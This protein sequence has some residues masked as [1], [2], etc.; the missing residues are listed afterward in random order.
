MSEIK[1]PRRTSDEIREDLRNIVNEAF[2][3]KNAPDMTTK[4]SISRFVSGLLSESKN[5]KLTSFLLRV[6]E[7]LQSENHRPEYLMY[8]SFAQGLVPFTSSNKAVKSVIETINENLAENQNMLNAFK[9]ASNIDDE[10]VQSQVMES[11]NRFFANPNDMT[12]DMLNDTLESLCEF[13][14]YS[15]IS[16]RI[17]EIVN[18]I[19][20]AEPEQFSTSAV[21]EAHQFIREQ[22]QKHDEQMSNIIMQRVEKYLNERDESDAAARQAA[23]Q[24][25]TLENVSNKM[26]LNEKVSALMS[27]RDCSKN[28]RLSELL[29]RYQTAMNHGCYQER[30]YEKLV[31]DLTPFNYLLPVNETI[32]SIKKLAG[33]RPD[34]IMLTRLLQEMSENGS[35]YIYTDLIV[36]DV[37]RF[38][39][40]PSSSSM[41]QA[42]NA[43]M[44]YAADPYVN[45][46]LK[47]IR[48]ASDTKDMTISISEQAM[49]IADQIKMIRENVTVETM[50]SPVLFIREN[51]SV[52]AIPNQ[53]YYLKNGNTVCPLDKKN[54]SQ[55][56]ESFVRLA[57]LVAQPNVHIDENCIYVNGE[58][59]W[60]TVYRDRVVLSNGINEYVE[61]AESLRRLDEMCMR[62][63]TYDGN[64]FLQTAALCENFDNIA[65]VSFAKKITLN[66]NQNITAVLYRLDENLFLSLEN[67]DTH[68]RTFYRNVNPIFCKNAI[69]EHFQINVSSLFEDLLPSQDKIILRLNETKNE[70]EKS[71]EKYEK[72]L[73]DLR[74]AK[75]NATSV[76]VER[77]ID[78]AIEDAEQKLRDVKDEYLQWQKETEEV[79]KGKSS[80]D[81]SD[82]KK[83]NKK[84]E[85]EDVTTEVSNEPLDADEVEQYKDELSQPLQS[86]ENTAPTEEA[87]S[88][89]A[90]VSDDEF[91]NYLAQE[92]P[93][94]EIPEES[95]E[96]EEDAI[97]T[98]QEIEDVAAEEEPE[99]FP[100]VN[101]D[102][103]GTG[104]EGIDDYSDEDIFADNDE[105]VTLGD[106]VPNEEISDEEDVIIPAEGDEDIYS[107]EEEIGD[108]YKTVDA[109][110]GEVYNP[111]EAT[112]IFGG[113][114]ESPIDNK[115]IPDTDLYNPHTETSEFNIVNVMFDENVKEGT[116]SKSGEVMLLRPMID[117]DG[118]KYTE[119][120]T[121]KFY[122]NSEN[123][124]VIEIDNAV[125][126][127]MYAAIGDA[128][129]SHPGY[130][131]VVANGIAVDGTEVAPVTVEETPAETPEEADAADAEYAAEIRE[132]ETAEIVTTEDEPM[133][134]MLPGESVDEIPDEEIDIDINT[135]ETIPDEGAE[136]AVAP[137]VSIEDATDDIFADIDIE[138]DND[139]VQT[140]TEP[141]GTEVE[142]PAPDA[143]KEEDEENKDDE[144]IIP[145]SEKTKAESSKQINESRNKILGVKKTTGKHPF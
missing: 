142:I 83:D 111:A 64:F 16:A 78:S 58:D 56:D 39:L 29:E 59:M 31:S 91:S 117:T 11:L 124:P 19:A 49:S 93:D 136:V 129:T 80:D 105:N 38:I 90:G 63:Q 26:G 4:F 66:S 127:A 57:H 27:N 68:S 2:Q 32:E 100:M 114:T 53:G 94:G 79:G 18:G 132:P 89:V 33:E 145:E 97:D 133:T 119:P 92:T 35:S 107:D 120:Q 42:V 17:S 24:T 109:E 137:E 37:T 25:F 65:P 6:N 14:E 118:H 70:Y 72:A 7:E 50:Y 30:I 88:E 20:S 82:E 135:G 52:F 139:P 95:A 55:L 77:E 21:N 9:L 47:V 98:E 140:Y 81:D 48:N 128:I 1:L 62:Y 8:E 5:P 134:D 46:M 22:T 45:E 96:E 40:Y 110:T 116:I 108:E 101:V 144:S 104:D 122:L 44:P 87:G 23:A 141:D 3:E 67:A 51:Q 28:V 13:Q 54:V 131:N 130:A 85:P 43:L 69:N 121:V 115:S 41:T 113:D 71:I 143:D 73:D 138:D 61:D 36:E 102:D 106:N 125:S 34:A 10:Q 126:T 12:R 60:A 76:D 112:D 123:K 74:D 15:I 75:E 99:A 103:Y 84:D 86:G